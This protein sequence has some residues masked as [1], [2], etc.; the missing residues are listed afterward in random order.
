M[1][2]IS[3]NQVYMKNPKEIKHFDMNVGSNIRP[4]IYLMC[5]SFISKGF[6]WLVLI[7]VSLKVVP[8]DLAA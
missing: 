7:F 2:Y 6:W 4:L 3:I 1:T 8:D 5:I